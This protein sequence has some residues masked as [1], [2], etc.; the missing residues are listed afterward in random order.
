LSTNRPEKDGSMTEREL[1]RG[2]KG[3]LLV[4]ALVFTACERRAEQRRPPVENALP[5]PRTV[6][7]F[8]PL[9][10]LNCAGCHGARGRGG[11]AIELASHSYLAWACDADLRRVIAEGR[12]RTAMPAFAQSAGGT[13]SDKQVDALV[14][15][16]RSWAASGAP[17]DPGA[18]PY[19]ASTKGDPEQGV[20]VFRE[21]CAVCHGADGRGVKGV[22]SIV[23][24]PFLELVSEQSLRTTIVTGRPDLGCPGLRGS[25]WT[26]LSADGVSDTVAWLLGH[27]QQFAGR[28]YRSAQADER[29]P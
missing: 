23:S 17:C 9:Y 16:I 25:G 27:R 26:P 13:L 11:A 22:G 19:E 28:P 8:A 29:K 2:A 10:S 21:H 20:R 24:E 12:Q 4:L 1:T 15:G 14:A 3:L 6:L 18:L 5:D 7:N